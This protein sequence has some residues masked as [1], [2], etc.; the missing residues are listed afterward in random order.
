VAGSSVYAFGLMVFTFLVGLSLGGEAARRLLLLRPGDPVLPLIAALLGL[1]VSVALGASFWNSIPDYFASFANYPAAR[2]FAS[3]EV[4]RGLVCCIVMIPPTLFIG[5]AYVLAMDIVTAGQQRRSTL[6]LGI[7]SAINTLGNITGVLLFGFVLL[8]LTGGLEAGRIIAIAA[9]VLA[10]I[11]TVLT[12]KIGKRSIAMAGAALLTLLATSGIRLDYEAL[13]SG[14]NVYF[15]PQKWG[16]VIDHAESIDGGLTTVTE[17]DTPTGRS[18]TLLTNGKFQGN[19]STGGEMQAQVGF[20]LAPLLHQ[21]KRERA[22]VIGY[23]T[24]VTTRVFHEAGFAQ[25][26]VAELSRDIVRLA[27][28]HFAKVNHRVSTQPGVQM[29]ITDGRN[30]LLLSTQRFDVISLEI[31]S[32]WFAGAASLYN[33]EFYKLARSKMQPDGVLQQWMQL[34]RLTPVDLLQIVASL[35]SEFSFVSLYVMGS[36]GILVAT[37]AP[38]KRSPN[39][40]AMQAIESAPALADV[41]QI[42]GRTSQ[43]L[44]KDLLLDPQGIDRFLSGVGVDPKLWIST[45]DNLRLEYST[46]K[47]NVNGASESYEA[48]MALL[49]RYQNAP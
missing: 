4:V 19:D 8:P 24:G 39:D 35:R 47:A 33:Q 34:H 38:D 26:E 49:K 9:F 45:D 7:G 42:A 29:R 18:L 3:R 48:N 17:A 36:Q 21:D 2:S 28:T 23:G 11:V 37:N 27:D 5:A 46:P 16:K 40:Q 14:A 32:I 15:Y 20:A 30:L 10:L 12:T 6:A 41:R 1:S 43:A 25:V 44:A 31:T 13:S 22:L